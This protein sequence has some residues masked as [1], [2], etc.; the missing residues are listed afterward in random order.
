MWKKYMNLVI[1]LYGIYF[2][3]IL[4]LDYFNDES[5]S[6]CLSILVW[7][8]FFILLVKNILFIILYIWKIKLLYGE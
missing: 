3:N 7:F 1:I 8:V 6:S 4:L 5:I 2:Y